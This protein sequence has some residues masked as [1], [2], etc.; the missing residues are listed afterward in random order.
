M[1]KRLKT[2]ARITDDVIA[3]RCTPETL[4]PKLRNH[5]VCEIIRAADGSREVVDGYNT[6]VNAGASWQ[7]QVMG[8]SNANPASWIALSTSTLTYSTVDTTLV[9]EVN[10]TGLSRA[11][12]TFSYTAAPTSTG[13]QATYTISKTFTAGTAATIA[14]AAM[15][16]SSGSGA[17]GIF[18]EANLSPAATLANNDQLVLTWTVNI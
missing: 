16:N 8:S 5:V 12:G 3:G 18:V 13:G 6:R 15:F 7:A 10:T 17:T 2:M 9:G 11:P 4:I 14:S 1:F